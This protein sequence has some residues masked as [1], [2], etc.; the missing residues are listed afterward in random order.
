MGQIGRQ[1]K[2]DSRSKIIP[3]RQKCR[4]FYYERKGD[5]LR[6]LTFVVPKQYD[7]A[8][9]KSF[10]RG[11]CEVSVGILTRLKWVYD[12]ITINGEHAYVTKTIFDGDVVRLKLPETE[13][14]V[15]PYPLPLSIV[16]EDPDVMV[17][18]KPSFMPVYP[19]PGHD[20]DSLANAVAYEMER[21]GEEFA[22]HPIYRLD[23]NTSGL[24]VLAKHCYSASLLAFGVEKRYYAICEGVLQGAD[25]ID[26]PI[27][28]K[29]GHGIQREVGEGG[30]KAVTH[31]KA[32][33]TKNHH[34]LLEISLETGRTHQIRV[35]FSA[36]GHPLAGDDM[37]GGS[38]ESLSRQALHCGYAAF[39]HPVTKEV[40][41]FRLPLPKDL[42]EFF[43]GE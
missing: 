43:K 33:E 16:Y 15:E 37:Y 29:E 42:E 10:L 12:G 22:F 30:Q 14:N 8:K 11:P 39:Q 26:A 34:T 13:S 27:R 38:R 32:L 28:L 7:G 9:L 5:S 41:E 31:W 19:T 25:T 3:W 35:H 4:L 20:R 23:K 24:L 2:L 18:N 17:I 21:R 40:M 36:I 6:E 1:A